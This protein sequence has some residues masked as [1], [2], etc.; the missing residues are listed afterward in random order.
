MTVAT[1]ERMWIHALLTELGITCTQ[2]HSLWC[3]NLFVTFPVANRVFHAHTKHIEL[4]F[5]FVQEQLTSKHITVHF[6]CSAN[7]LADVLTKSLPK[8][9]FCL[10]WNKL[11]ICSKTAE[12]EGV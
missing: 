8:A 6:V 5:H 10:L 7:Q 2:L 3:D 4:D 9:R 12:L 11:T 1:T